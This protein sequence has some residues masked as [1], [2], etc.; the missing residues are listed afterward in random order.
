MKMKATLSVSYKLFA[1]SASLM[2]GKKPTVR[3]YTLPESDVARILTIHVDPAVDDDDGDGKR[4]AN[5]PAA[6]IAGPA[7]AAGAGAGALQRVDA[8]H[9]KVQPRV[10][11]PRAIVGKNDS[12]GHGD[13]A[14]LD[15]IA[16]LEQLVATG[17]KAPVPHPDRGAEEAARHAASGLGNVP[18]AN[19]GS[20]VA[21]LAS[22]M[23]S[24]AQTF[25]WTTGPGVIAGGFP[26]LRPSGTTN[27]APTSNSTG[28][29]PPI[30]NFA[31]GMD[32]L[33]AMVV[34]QHAGLNQRPVD[35]AA[36]EITSLDQQ[37]T[38]TGQRWFD[39]MREHAKQYKAKYEEWVHRMF[40][41]M[42]TH[43]ERLL[44]EN[45]P[46]EDPIVGWLATH[47][48][49]LFYSAF[50]SE[51][52]GKVLL[53]RGYYVSHTMTDRAAAHVVSAGPGVSKRN[54]SRATDAPTPGRNAAKN[55]DRRERQKAAR[56]RDATE[57]AS[58]KG[59]KAKKGVGAKG[60]DDKKEN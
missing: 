35:H 58:L 18:N 8:K 23:K 32:P 59:T 25:G 51:Q 48:M 40:L 33:L 43:L 46:W 2:T 5:N 50:G 14:L 9:A 41:E 21:G 42:V 53:F 11:I 24:H 60:D 27:V 19:G 55:K 49:A 47:V 28:A 16:Y 34:Q 57:L 13:R 12:D 22:E 31:P 20:S 54:E 1:N 4:P 52:S 10:A 39:L 6:P 15:R 7:P 44:K 3:P 45:R 30:P 17:V 38:F 26:N 56:K 37:A 29:L 36:R